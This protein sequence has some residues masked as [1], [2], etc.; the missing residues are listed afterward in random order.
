MLERNIKWILLVS[1]LLNALLVGF[2]AANTGRGKNPFASAMMQKR[3]DMERE[4][5]DRG[6]DDDVTRTAL[7]TALDAERSAM[8]QAALMTREARKKSAELIRAETLDATA[9]D[10]AL[11]QLRA[12][13]TEQLEAFHRAIRTTAAT[14]N[15]E[16]RSKLARLL[17][18]E[19]GQR[20]ERGERDKSDRPPRPPGPPLGG[21]PQ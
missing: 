21:P 17:D 4:R 20:G 11:T 19:P 5:S 18:R 14:L 1:L 12:G 13:R 3:G 10:A 15:T 6:K 9:L 7:K 2:I 16:Q 8:D